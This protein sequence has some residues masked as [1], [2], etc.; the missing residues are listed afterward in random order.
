[1]FYVGNSELN[2]RLMTCVTV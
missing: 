2:L 1:M